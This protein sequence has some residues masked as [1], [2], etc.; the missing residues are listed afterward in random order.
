MTIK[1]S[2]LW[3]ANNNKLKSIISLEEIVIQTLHLLGYICRILTL[4]PYLSSEVRHPS[5]FCCSFLLIFWPNIRPIIEAIQQNLLLILLWLLY[6]FWNLQLSFFRK[7]LN[8][9]LQIRWFT[10]LPN[11]CIVLLTKRWWTILTR[12]N[13]LFLLLRCLIIFLPLYLLYVMPDLPWIRKRI[14]TCLYEII[15]SHLI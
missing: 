14:S 12:N 1:F 2:L 10:L 3:L 5:R 7:I 11:S 8:L 4:R 13:I 9:F 6:R 15:Q